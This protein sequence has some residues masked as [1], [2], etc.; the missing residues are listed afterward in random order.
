MSVSEKVPEDAS[1]SAPIT[2]RGQRI[3]S[4]ILF[5]CCSRRPVDELQT[6][7]ERVSAHNAV[8]AEVVA[9]IQEGEI[10][11]YSG[12]GA[13]VAFPVDFGEFALRCAAARIIEKLDTYVDPPGGGVIETRVGVSAGD[14]QEIRYRGG[15]GARQGE[16]IEIA[17]RLVA[18]V[19]ES[20]QI[21]LDERAKRGVT[22][23]DID[24]LGRDWLQA[25][26]V[27]VEGMPLTMQGV[28]KPIPMFQ[29]IWKDK[30]ERPIQNR[31]LLAIELTELQRKVIVLHFFIVR[32]R[33]MLDD[34][35]G[36]EN[37]EGLLEG[38][39]EEAGPVQALLE[40]RDR[41]REATKLRDTQDGIDTVVQRL[42][43]LNELWEDHAA[44]VRVRGED[45]KAAATQCK[46]AYGELHRAVRYL[47]KLLVRTQEKLGESL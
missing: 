23:G 32:S 39:N 6:T 47:Y 26:L 44:M 19:A 29:L 25:K 41:L 21:V 37:F 7:L 15:P 10:F 27:P 4:L 40:T 31:W 22:P 28:V 30:E 9:E 2:E 12:D 20:H 38:L 8:V 35:D 18:D 16:P 42:K 13:L 46:G 33:P 5:A 24:S 45:G 11:A 1:A 36:I 34:D 43:A 3:P 14:V 17:T